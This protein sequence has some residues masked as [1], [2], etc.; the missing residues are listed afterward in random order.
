MELFG[1]IVAVSSLFGA[2]AYLVKGKEEKPI[3]VY[4]DYQLFLEAAAIY[5]E[6]N[7]DYAKDLKKMIPFIEHAEQLNF[8]RYSLSLDGK[9]LVVNQLK[10]TESK[11]IINEIGGESYINGSYAY[12]TLMRFNDVSKVKPVARF[13]MHPNSDYSTTTLI[14]YSLEGCIAEDDEIAEVKWENK[15]AIFREPGI[16]SIRLKIRDKNNN[17]SDVF[18]KEIKVVEEWGIRSIAA[19]DDSFFLIYNNGKVLSRGKNEFGQLGV[20]T[21][22]PYN[23]LK[24]NSLHDSVAEIACGEGFNVFRF[25][26]GSVGTAG[27]N[28][29]GELATGDK[30][31]Q[32]TI[33]LIWGLDNIVQVAAGKNFAAALDAEG[34]VFAWGDNTDNQL[35]R[36]DMLDAVLPVKISGLEGIK[37]IALGAN[38][39]LALRHDGMV[40]GWGD[41]SSGQLGLGHKYPILE[42]TE[43]LYE[44]V[45]NVFAGDKFSEA[46]TETG[47]VFGAGNNAYGQLGFRGKSE[48]HTPTRIPIGE[49]MDLCVRESLTVATLNNGVLVVWGNFSG[50]GS[51]PIFDP[52][53][54]V[55]IEKPIHMTNNGKKCFIIDE[56]YNFYIV[57]D[58]MG[59]YA[60][61]K[62]FENFR[63]FTNSIEE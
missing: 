12:L 38:F 5:R 62:V 16:Y 10:E 17:W 1:I 13:S 40:M 41:N 27:N 54:L 55:D 23:E 14:T 33:K 4:K 30:S 19:Y 56:E 29:R 2:V 58:M 63:D 34:Y 60:K 9:F 52:T 7:G 3:D 26:D 44:D 28:R 18:E 57:S 25:H 37:Q 11:A 49:V 22:N 59:K 50:P 15:Q 35:M 32:K 20:A 31:S 39:G 43:T 51:K 53:Q 24:Y 47:N 48:I 45:I 46:I 42:P 6:K 36:D 21:L 8:K 61:K